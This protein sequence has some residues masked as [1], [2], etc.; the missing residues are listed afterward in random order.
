MRKTQ[1]AMPIA[2]DEKARAVARGAL[3]CVADAALAE[4]LRR[5]LNL[6]VHV[7]SVSLA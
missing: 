1:N 2:V 6:C 5:E 3:L 7:G 4:E